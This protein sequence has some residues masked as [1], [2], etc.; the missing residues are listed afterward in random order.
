MPGVLNLQLLTAFIP[1]FFLVSVTPGM[2]MTLS[3]SLG[4]SI[5]VRRT[6]WMMAGELIGV[7]IV[8]TS[9]VVG[10]A[11]LMLNYPAI[12]TVLK[13]AGG[14]YLLWLGVQMWLSRGRMAMAD[15]PKDDDT[16]TVS[17]LQLATQGFVTA[18]ANPKGWAFFV[19]LLPPFI[20]TT[21]PMAPQLSVLITLILMLELSCLVLYAHGGQNLHRLLRKRGNVRLLNRIS[22]TLLIGV[23]VWLAL[24]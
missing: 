22:G 4:I 8:A 12:F 15:A 6:L 18:I 13:W 16:E 23:G 3:M 11:A 5:G 10:V 17:R 1:T 9:A 20:D 24:G 7:G 2:C 21:L 14:A 19:V